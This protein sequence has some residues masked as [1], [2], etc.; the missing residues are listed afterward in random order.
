MQVKFKLIKK[1]LIAK[2]E[3]ELD[4]HT[5]IDV[6]EIIDE[7]ISKSRITNLIFDFTDLKF[8]DSSGIGVVI[9]RYKKIEK[10]NGKLCLTTLNPHIKRIVT[11]S[12][13]H[14]I[15]PVYNNVQE[16]LKE[17]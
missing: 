13:L 9:G 14:K 10:L 7:E 6:R 5:S 11:I 8:M 2:I 15:I 12:G 1:T 16:A 4:H 17:M 3:G